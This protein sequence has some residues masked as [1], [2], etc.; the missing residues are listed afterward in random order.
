MKIPVVYIKDTLSFSCKEKQ[1]N[2]LLLQ[3]GFFVQDI[4]YFGDSIDGEIGSL[5]IDQNFQLS[6]N[7]LSRSTNQIIQDSLEVIQQS[8][9]MYNPQLVVQD[10][11]LL[12]DVSY[13]ISDINTVNCKQTIRFNQNWCN[14]DNLLNSNLIQYNVN[15][16]ILVNN[17]LYNT[18]NIHRYKFDIRDD[19]DFFVDSKKKLFQDSQGIKT[20][21]Q[22]NSQKNDLTQ[23]Q[24]LSQK[25]QVDN[26]QYR[27][28]SSIDGLII[29]NNI[30]LSVGKHKI[31]IKKYNTTKVFD[32]DIQ[33]LS[34][35]RRQFKNVYMLDL[36]DLDNAKYYSDYQVQQNK[37][38]LFD[39]NIEIS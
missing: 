18:F 36:Y 25:L 30:H 12:K 15:A 2:S 11:M 35:Y 3:D 22:L 4:N 31:K 29:N 13:N 5:K 19:F 6:D 17:V 34:P 14:S 1:Q 20:V 26:K 10:Y 23:E 39:N 37:V 21:V 38:Q 28:I 9:E 33:I 16:D 8:F 24:L 32:F 27:I 7:Y